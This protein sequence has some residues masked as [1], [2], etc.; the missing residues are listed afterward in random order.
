MSKELGKI[1]VEQGVITEDK[2]HLALIRQKRTRKK[3]GRILVDLQL[4]SED[5]VAKALAKQLLGWEFYDK[6]ITPDFKALDKLQLQ[7]CRKNRVLPIHLNGN[8][9]ETVFLFVDPYD[10]KLTDQLKEQGFSLILEKDKYYISTAS[11]INAVLNEIEEKGKGVDIIEQKAKE[12]TQKGFTYATLAED[13]IDLL[14]KEAIACGATDIHI[15]S[16]PETS[17][18]RFRIDGILYPI[19]SLLREHHHN[20]VNVLYNRSGINPENF[21]TPHDCRIKWIPKEGKPIDIR[22][23]SIP[24][25]HAAIASASICLR[26]FDTEKKTWPLN[27]LGYSKENISIINKMVHKPHGMM[28]VTG[29]TGSGK[30]TTLYTILSL[31]KSVRTKIITIEDPIEME[32]SM[33]QQEQV[34]EANELTFS[35][36]LRS[37]LR[38]DPDIILIGEIRDP[39]TAQEAIRASI[40]GHLVFSTLHTNTAA[41]SILRLVDLGVSPEYIVSSVICL[42]SQ[43]LVRKLCPAC[44]QP[45]KISSLS[46]DYQ[47]IIASSPY[48]KGKDTVYVPSKCSHCIGGYRSRMVVAEVLPLSRDLHPFVLKLDPYSLVET[49]KEKYN[50]QTIHQDGLRLIAQGQTSFAEIERVVGFEF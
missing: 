3:L 6:A 46:D 16:T 40:T 15:E 36:A 30:T 38:H 44:K 20:L 5:D 21:N 1:L 9:N 13:F 43:R 49:A 25:K 27:A 7:F 12:I 42:V 48:F 17:D 22:L 29:P 10:T 39:E 31:L 2:L 41:D 8:K 24:T 23:S 33:V 50:F 37:I 4:V 28:I 18:I 47:K 34:D 14:M 11:R 35:K 45:V 32:M 26:I 19:V